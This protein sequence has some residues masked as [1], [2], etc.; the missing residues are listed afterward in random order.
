MTEAVERKFYL[1]EFRAI[2]RA[3]AN[4]EDLTTL[5]NHIVQ[6]LSQTFNVKGCCVMLLEERE[7]QFIQVGSYGISDEY[8]SKGP[9]IVDPEHCAFCQKIPV[10][11]EDLQ[12]DPRVQYPEEAIKENVHSMLSVPIKSRGVVIGMLRMY[13][14]EKINLHYDDIESITILAELAGLVIENFGLRNFLDSVKLSMGNLP[15]RMLEGL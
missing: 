14:S 10:L 11:I 4:Y 7:H 3:I 6:G 5:I 8:L 9:I 2:A 12:D 1:K 15:L 13:H